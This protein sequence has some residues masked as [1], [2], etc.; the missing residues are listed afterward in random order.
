MLILNL[1]HLKL[2]IYLFLIY[3]YLRS[4]KSTERQLTEF[5]FI[6]LVSE[7]LQDPGR[8]SELGT[9]AHVPTWLV[10]IQPLEPSPT[11][12]KD[13]C[14]SRKKKLDMEPR[15]ESRHTNMGCGISI[16]SFTIGQQPFLI[17]S[18]QNDYNS[19]PIS[20]IS[21]SMVSITQSALPKNNE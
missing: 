6:G 3:L 9:W 21:V 11:I 14:I 16:G 1:F 8:S 12:S 13:V 17:C 7:C 15:S 10:G 5:P 2:F 20:M 4:R 19:P 18:L